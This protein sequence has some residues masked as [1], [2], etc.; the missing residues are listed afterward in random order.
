[1]LQAAQLPT[2]CVTSSPV[3]FH[4]LVPAS[5]HCSLSW[6]ADSAVDADVVDVAGVVCEVGAA[7][8]G[9]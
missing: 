7:A 8:V 2:P 5:G 9:R 4:V 6:A 1:M 3:L